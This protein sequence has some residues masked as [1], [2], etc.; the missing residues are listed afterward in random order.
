MPKDVG[1]PYVVGSHGDWYFLA[2]G[3]GGKHASYLEVNGRTLR[4][5]P[6]NPRL[7]QEYWRDMENV[8]KVKGE[9]P[10]IEAQHVVGAVRQ[11]IM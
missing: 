8:Q 6:G 9:C 2:I 3:Q 10:K 5:R 7:G 11:L 1:F 4:T